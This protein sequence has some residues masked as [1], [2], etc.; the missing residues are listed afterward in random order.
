VSHVAF[1]R[2]GVPVVGGLDEHGS[3]L[4]SA[5]RREFLN[6]FLFFF[7]FFFFFLAIKEKLAHRSEYHTTAKQPGH[8]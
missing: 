4:A 3:A 6:H 1:T 2:T 7:F 8:S 5:A